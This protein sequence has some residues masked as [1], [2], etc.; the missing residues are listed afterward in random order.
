MQLIC[1][2]CH[3]YI[4]KLDPIFNHKQCLNEDGE[5]PVRLDTENLEE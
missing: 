1:F 3:Q 4:S 5:L 2:I